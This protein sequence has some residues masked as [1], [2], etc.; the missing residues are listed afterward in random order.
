[1]QIHYQLRENN[2]SAGLDSNLGGEDTYNVDDKSWC[3]SAQ[4]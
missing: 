2:R 3:G 4:V 1:M